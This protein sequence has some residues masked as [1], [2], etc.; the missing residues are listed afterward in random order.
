MDVWEGFTAG[1]AERSGG[2][3]MAG[4]ELAKDSASLR[5]VVLDSSS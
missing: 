4:A 1:K 3:A 5:W 2:A